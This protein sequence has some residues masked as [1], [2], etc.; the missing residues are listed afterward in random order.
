MASGWPITLRHGDLVVR[1]LTRNDAH[2]W[3]SLRAENVA[4]LGP[5][6]ASV[7]PGAAGAPPSFASLIG[8]LRRSARAGRG[9]P[10][11]VC[12]CDANGREVMVGQL[13]VSNIT[14]GSA[15]WA[16]IGYWIVQSHAGRGITPRAVAM[17][18]D[19]LFGPVG[20][21]RVE[22]SLRPENDR[23]RRVVEK[24]GFT[25]VGR[26]PRFLHIDG[27]WRDH[28]IFQLLAEDRPAG[29]LATYESGRDLA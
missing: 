23:S 9:M 29:V 2:T 12:E 1:P 20:L 11:V 15:Q 3:A 27:D 6:E 5:W 8:R 26:A 13:N 19:H 14:R 4:W 7:P 28:D 24:L 25:H 10:F 22:I 17:V 18:C 21:H 16:A